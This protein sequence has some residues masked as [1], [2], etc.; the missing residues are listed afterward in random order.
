LQQPFDSLAESY[1]KWYDTQR[2]KQIFET[3]LKCLQK[4][5][6]TCEGRW[7]D[8][9]VGTGRFSSR[10]EIK[11]GIDPSPFMLELAASRGITTYL[12]NAEEFPFDA[13]SFDGILMAFTLCFIKAP[14]K[15]LSQCHRILKDNGQFLIGL[16]P[17]KSPWGKSYQKKKKQGHP[18]YSHAHF[19]TIE[20]TIAIAKTSGFKLKKSACTLFCKPD[21]LPQACLNIEPGIFE[22]AGFSAMLFSKTG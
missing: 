2:G 5:C 14:E 1:D 20:N 15:A 17:A 7:L 6:P 3:E 16:I 10:M 13:S 22:H 19:L 11:E 8:I 18:I 21:E 4:V 12:G 9:G